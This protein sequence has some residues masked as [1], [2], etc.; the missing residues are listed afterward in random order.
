M[1]T[2]DTSDLAKKYKQS[3]DN[4]LGILKANYHSTDIEESTKHMDIVIMNQFGTSN[5]SKWLRLPFRCMIA[6]YMAERL[7]PALSLLNSIKSTFLRLS[8]DVAF[9]LNSNLKRPVIIFVK[10]INTTGHTIR[11]DTFDIER[12][13]RLREEIVARL[14]ADSSRLSNSRRVPWSSSERIRLLAAR[15]YY[16]KLNSHYHGVWMYIANSSLY[17]FLFNRTPEQMKD[18][19]TRITKLPESTLTILN[20]SAKVWRPDYFTPCDIVEHLKAFNINLSENAIELFNSLYAIDIKELRLAIAVAN[21]IEV[22]LPHN[23]LE[24]HDVKK[25]KVDLD[26]SVVVNTMNEIKAEIAELKTRINQM[27]QNIINNLK[28][29][30]IVPQHSQLEMYDY[31]DYTPPV[32]SPEPFEQPSASII[33]SNVNNPKHL[34]FEKTRYRVFSS[35]ILYELS[36]DMTVLNSLVSNNA[37]SKLEDDSYKFNLC[38]AASGKY[39]TAEYVNE[40]LVRVLSKT[41]TGDATASHVHNKIYISLRPQLAEWSAYLEDLVSDGYLVITRIKGKNSKYYGMVSRQ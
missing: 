20:N 36:I 33:E 16:F 21:D 15:E 39:I 5:N 1:T 17:G 37:V 12:N 32:N 7:V 41:D 22:E 3:Y 38:S 25:R 35:S 13:L 29:T 34:I 24:N 27:E 40:L 18:T 23:L 14:N 9:N 28:N 10:L 19:Y 4:S 30:S 2:L 8:L 6:Y 11:A 26:L 31:D